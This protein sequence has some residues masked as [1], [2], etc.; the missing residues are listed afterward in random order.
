MKKFYVIRWKSNMNG[1]AGRGTKQ[2]EKAEAEELVQELN[3][4]HP[5]IVHEIIE[6]APAPPG[7]LETQPASAIPLF[8]IA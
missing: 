1:R 6:A 4:D 8:S 5:Q 2:F 3:H 7:Q